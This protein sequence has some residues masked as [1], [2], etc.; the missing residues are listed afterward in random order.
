MCEEGDVVGPE[1]C[2]CENDLNI[3]TL[4]FHIDAL[5][6]EYLCEENHICW[7][8]KC[9]DQCEDLPLKNTE[10]CFCNEEICNSQL[11]LQ[12]AFPLNGYSTYSYCN[13]TEGCLTFDDCPQ[14]Y[15]IYTDDVYCACNG[16][17]INSTTH[18]CMNNETIVLPEECPLAPQAAPELGC[19]CNMTSICTLDLMCLQS[20]YK[21]SCGPRPDP[22]PELP[23]VAGPELCYCELSVEICDIGMSCGGENKNCYYPAKCP[24]F[25]WE[26]INVTR[27]GRL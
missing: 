9:Y 22:C 21:P 26:L 20:G 11:A 18:Y 15:S 12:L 13:V 25:D 4:E 10:E 3:P 16:T 27:N 7:R 1:R 19:T 5:D 17:L 8:S 6:G 14:D 2:L 24:E 23:Q